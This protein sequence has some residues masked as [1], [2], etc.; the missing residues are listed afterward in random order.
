MSHSYK[1][2][3]VLLSLFGLLFIGGLATVFSQEKIWRD[4]TPA[5]LQMKTPQVEPD[6][7]AEAIFWE[8]RL[9]DKKLGKL[10]YNHYVRVKIF[11][12]RG[13]E[14]FSKLDIPFYKGKKVEDVAARVIKA[15]G[16]IINLPPTDIFEREIVSANKIKI[17]AKSFAVPGIEP[18]VIVEYQYSETFKNDSAGGERLLFQRDIPMQRVTYY[19]RPYKG[20]NLRFI[21][22]NT[23]QVNFV[24]DE[25]RFYVGTINNVPA[26]K[27][28]PYMPPEDE[29]RQWT[30][31]SYGSSYSWQ[32]YSRNL[33]P[34]QNLMIKPNK[35]I[36]EQ[37]TAL[38]N[39]L[40]APE[41]KLRRLYTFVQTRIKNIS[42][43]KSLSEDQLDDLN[44]DEIEDVLKKGAGSS[45]Q[46]NLLYGALASAAGFE[47]RLFFSSNRSESFFNPDRVSSGSFLHPAG[48]GVNVGENKWR[49][50]DPGTPYLGFDDM[51]WHDQ[52]V[53]GM[54]I[55]NYSHSWV[56]TS[57]F[58]YERSA[59]RR[60]GKFNLLEDGT[61]EGEA[62]IEYTGNQ[63]IDRRQNGFKDSPAQ[64]EED[65]KKEIKEHISAAEISAI[66]IE[67]F[68]DTSKPLTY[69]FK[70]RVPG[71]AQ[72]TGKRLFIQPGYFEYGSNPVFSSATRTHAVYFPYPQS[73]F[74][75]VEIQLPKGFALDNADAPAPIEDPSK[76]ASL[77]VTI[78]ID[79]VT[80]S[81][82]YER[83]F[84]FGGGGNIYFPV[85][86]YP[87]LKNMFDSFHKADT[88]TITLK[89]N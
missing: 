28:E 6:A 50:L 16:T 83:R 24:E 52:S 39:G 21:P 11:T 75:K 5:E 57:I 54:L 33:S 69:I 87:A 78:G 60:S 67:N 79:K 22:F 27:Q 42:Y 44:I 37:T 9:D 63:A 3:F 2:Y 15:D 72:K 86:V 31:L 81:I 47:A 71:Y 1:N 82:K 70:V 62:R 34:L 14:K 68:N 13:R 80:N 46:V 49:F 30:L 23:Q 18:G 36:R 89:Q 25:N 74:D 84:Y 85:N 73:E 12:E 59:A 61:L 77:K 7:D 8:V 66:S 10:S 53:V 26:L 45:F 19:V 40:I 4:V 88:H 20:L 56:K 29:V 35:F 76:I 17:K 64:R 51:F 43:D 58:N 55:N 32:S 48:I 65:L 38:T 41:D